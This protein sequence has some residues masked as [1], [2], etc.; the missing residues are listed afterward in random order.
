[1]KTCDYVHRR[2]LADWILRALRRANPI[3]Q[4]SWRKI[5]KVFNHLRVTNWYLY[6]WLQ[7]GLCSVEYHTWKIAFRFI[8]EIRWIREVNGR[9]AS[10]LVR[11]MT[12]RG[13]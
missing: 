7:A 5:K 4:W 13:W 12:V 6:T 1:M 8:F 10:C 11:T 9:V 2:E 3:A